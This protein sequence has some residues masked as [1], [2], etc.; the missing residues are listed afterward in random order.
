M[1]TPTPREPIDVA[2]PGN[3]AD[4]HQLRQFAQQ[5]VRCLKQHAWDASMAAGAEASNV[6]RITIQLVNRKRE[7]IAARVPMTVLI[8]T[9]RSGAPSN[10]QT[11][12]VAAGVTLDTYTANAALLILTDGDGKIQLDVTVSG[13]ATRWIT[14][15]VPG[16]AAETSFDWA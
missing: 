1:T 14:A 9:S 8:A 12:S 11:V 3:P 16:W 4:A 10:S 2:V 5:A 7:P 13:A 6:R 15:V